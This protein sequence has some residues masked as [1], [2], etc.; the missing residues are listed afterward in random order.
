MDEKFNTCMTQLSRIRFAPDVLTR[1]IPKSMFFISVSWFYLVYCLCH[2]SVYQVYK[3]FV[4]DFLYSAPTLLT[5]TH[6]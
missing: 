3:C 2:F 6:I 5:N 1:R 4:Y